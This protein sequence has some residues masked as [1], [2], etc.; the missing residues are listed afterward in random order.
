MAKKRIKKSTQN[1][2]LRLFFYLMVLLILGVVVIPFT[3]VASTAPAL[4]VDTHA[5]FVDVRTNIAEYAAFFGISLGVL[6]V[7]VYLFKKYIIK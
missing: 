6:A 2:L 4:W 3:P 5:F 7:L 1:M